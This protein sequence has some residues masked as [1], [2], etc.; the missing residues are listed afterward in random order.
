MRSTCSIV[1]MPSATTRWASSPNGRPQR[2]TR[3]PGPSDG[4]DHPLA[5]RRTGA[6]GQGQGGLAGLLAGHDLEQAHERRR[7]EE[8]HAHDALGAGHGGGEVGDRQRRGVG[9]Q[10][11]RRVDHVGQL[12]EQPA[13]GFQRLG[14]GLDDQRARGQVL[15]AV[16]R[17]HACARSARVV[18]APA[19]ALG[20]LG[21][22][23][24][25]PL[26]PASS[27]SGTASNTSVRAPAS[28]A[29]WAMPEPMVPAPTTPMVEA[30]GPDDSSTALTLP[31]G[32][33]R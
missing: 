29:S 24:L 22:P 18:L 23:R 25:E 28:A 13:L 32:R 1:A 8:V 9:G 33:A 31:W 14:D 27:P 6:A 4:D 10:H 5:H 16:N 15:E 17:L 3:N 26:D 11:A 20:A 30:T 7:V 21:Q 12:P 2:L 19:P